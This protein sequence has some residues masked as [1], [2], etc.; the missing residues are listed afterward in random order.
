MSAERRL[1]YI[2]SKVRLVGDPLAAV[3]RLARARG[4]EDHVVYENG[5]QWA[6]ACG[7]LADIRLDRTGARLRGVRD[8]FLPWDG[9]PLRQVRRLLDAVPVDDWRVYGWA[10]FELAYAKNG[11]LTDVGDQRLLHLIVP[12]VEV[13]VEY[14]WAHVRSADAE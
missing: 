8:M 3:S 13:R 11:D 7:A 2:E 1:R 14:G 5:G 9:R 4:D 12:R 10:A 6:F